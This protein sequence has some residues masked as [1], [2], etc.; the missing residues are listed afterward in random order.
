VSL[1]DALDVAAEI[2]M[3]PLKE[4]E[5]PSSVLYPATSLTYV[6]LRYYFGSINK[7]LGFFS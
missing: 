7:V 1:H 2:K 4:I 3:H 6:I 5:P